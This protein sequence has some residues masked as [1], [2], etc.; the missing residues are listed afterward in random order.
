MKIRKWWIGIPLI[1]LVFSAIMISCDDGILPDDEDPSGNWY[2]TQ[3]KADNDAGNWTFQLAD[4]RLR[5]NGSNTATNKYTVSGNTITFTNVEGSQKTGTINFSIDGTR[6]ILDT[7]K[8]SPP[9]NPGTYY[10]KTGS[11]YQPPEPPINTTPAKPTANPAAGAVA[12]GT[13]VTLTTTPTDA[14]IRYTTNGTD[15]T[16][17]TGTVYTTPISITAATTIKAIAVKDGV[18]SEVLT[19]AYTITITPTAPAKP[20]ASP[21]AGAVAS[22]TTVTLTTTPTDAEIRYTTNGTDPTATTGTVYST[23]ISI[24]AATTI[25]AIAVKDGLSSDVLTAAYTISA[26]TSNVTVT[27]SSDSGANTLRAALTTVSSGGTIT[28]GASVTTIE[29]ATCLNITKNVTIKG[30]GV[31]IARK[32]DATTNYSL[33]EVNSNCDVNIERVHFKLGKEMTGGVYGGGAIYTEGSLKVESCIFSMNQATNGGAISTRPSVSNVPAGA[34]TVR[35][36]TFYNNSATNGTAINHASGTLFLTGNLFFKN[37]ATGNV[38]NKTGSATV[39]SYGYNIV[40]VDLGTGTNQSGFNDAKDTT[41][42]AKGVNISGAN[43]PFVD[44]TNFKPVAGLDG[45][46]NP[47]PSG[48]PTTD[49]SGATRTHGAPGA[50]DY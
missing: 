49:F 42:A 18:S 23:P 39:T 21:A 3:E 19:A 30:N 26:T 37:I 22:G 15:P 10:R 25:K 28:I 29:L 34:T 24:T 48:F 20:T 27:S 12:S 38:V 32:S 50:V 46:I 40:D 1:I 6:L 4:G 11:S 43:M 8:D 7:A 47:F 16:A 13:T 36:C 44:T 31:I 14:E 33:I 17:T 45:I 9:L 5:K 2:D 41:F 35:G